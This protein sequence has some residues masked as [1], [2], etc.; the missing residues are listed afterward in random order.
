MQDIVGD[1]ITVPGKFTINPKTRSFAHQIVGTQ[2]LID[3]KAFALFDEMGAGKSKQVIDAACFLA[4]R[5][6]IDTVVV[7]CP[8]SVRSVWCD[9]EIGEIKKHSWLSSHVFEFHK[10][11]KCIWSEQGNCIGSGDNWVGCLDWII[12][13][14]EFL[15]GDTHLS[16]L[17]YKVRGT[18]KTLLVLDESS[19]IKSRTAAQT[20]AVLRLRAHCARVVCLNGTPIVNNPLD[21]F[22][23]MKILSPDILGENFWQFRAHYCEMIPMKFGNGPRFN[24]IGS[25]KNLDEL[26]KKIAPYCLRRLKADCLDLPPKL[27]TQREVTLTPES[28]KRYQQLKYEAVIALG[29]GDLRLEPN[30]ATRIMR[31]AQ[32]T[33]GHLGGASFLNDNGALEA[34]ESPVNLSQ[35]Y[36]SEKL[37][38]C[39]RYLTEDCTASHVIVWCRWR[40]ERERLAER[41]RATAPPKEQQAYQYIF[42]LY[43]GQSHKEREHAIGCFTTAASGRGILLAQPH[44]GGF[45]LN[46]QIASEEWF[47]SNDWSY[48]VRLQAEDRAH[49][50]GQKS[51]VLIGDVLATGPAGQRTIDHAILAALRDK[52]NLAEMTTAAWRKELSN[53]F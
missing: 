34:Y 43:G 44:A 24:K 29:N 33:S 3:H 35:D 15:R 26:Q 13:N 40:R 14:Y 20:K 52:Q 28:W 8:A 21:L 17:L 10:K 41:L 6:E 48:G 2:A 51:N 27:Y 45:G 23:Q 46:L 32:L 18:S 31:L 5:G 19:Y 50:P 16:D 53:D 12:T 37:D 22:S 36:S 7:V 1:I 30:A 47:L 11:L 25:F 49:R 42:E 39:V 38:W 9:A 4:E